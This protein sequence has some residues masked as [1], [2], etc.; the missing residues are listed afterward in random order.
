MA[1]LIPLPEL[2]HA[3]M[4]R[5]G[6]PSPGYQ[7]VHRAISKGILTPERLGGRLFFKTEDLPKIARVLGIAVE[8]PARRTRCVIE[9]R[10]TRQK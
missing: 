4:A 5:Y 9:T 7:H 2:G 1:N 3:I 8:K 6:V 10:V